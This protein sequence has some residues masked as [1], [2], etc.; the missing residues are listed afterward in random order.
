[1]QILEEY[2]RDG[3]ILVGCTPDVAVF[4]SEVPIRHLEGSVN[5]YASLREYAV[6]G[7]IAS[8]L[9]DIGATHYVVANAP[10]LPA[11]VSCNIVIAK[12]S[13]NSLV[14]YGNYVRHN[15]DVAIYRITLSSAL[16]DRGASG[17]KCGPSIEPN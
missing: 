13:H 10:V 14:A 9:E 16:V 7:R 5:G 3:N 11:Y 1:V 15:G 12:N 8:Y 2:D 4:Y 17:S 6:P